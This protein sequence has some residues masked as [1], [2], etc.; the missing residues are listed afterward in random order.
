M[1]RFARMVS[2]GAEMKILLIVIL[3]LVGLAILAVITTSIISFVGNYAG[4]NSNEDEA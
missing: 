2:G 3:A 1:G 4:A